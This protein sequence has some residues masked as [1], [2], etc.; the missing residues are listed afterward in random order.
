MACGGCS[1]KARERR[2]SRSVGRDNKN[3]T[4]FGDHKYLSNKQIEA[5]LSSYKRKNC[6]ECEKRYDCNY[7]SFLM[8]KERN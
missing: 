1:R 8:C 6:K 3:N 5:R 7:K 2:M 4:L